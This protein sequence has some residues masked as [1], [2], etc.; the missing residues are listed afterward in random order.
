MTIMTDRHYLI[1]LCLLN[2][3]REE[4][5]QHLSDRE[6]SIDDGAPQ[7]DTSQHSASERGEDDE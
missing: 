5:L 4:E 1:Y 7:D 2:V 6:L 3:V